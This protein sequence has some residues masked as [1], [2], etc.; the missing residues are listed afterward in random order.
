M[1]GSLWPEASRFH[2]ER[3][4]TNEPEPSAFKFI[5]FNAGWLF[6][7]A[8]LCDSAGPRICL[9]QSMAY[10]EAKMALAMLLQRF[11]VQVTPGSPIA[12]KFSEANMDALAGQDPVYLPSLTLP[13][14]FGLKARAQHR[15]DLI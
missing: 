13:R 15:T 7:C 2:P 9:G 10:V 5:A 4:M 3:W 1:N 12:C 14:K 6:M 8:A 11:H